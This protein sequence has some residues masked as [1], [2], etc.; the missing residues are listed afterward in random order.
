M[1]GHP[2]S[3]PAPRAG[4]V[5]LAGRSRRGVGAA[6]RVVS[7]WPPAHFPPLPAWVRPKSGPPQSATRPKA[8][9]VRGPWVE[10]GS[11]PRG[12]G[13]AAA[14]PVPTAAGTWA[15]L[16]C[17][18]FSLE[19]GVCWK[20]TREK[21]GDGPQG[22]GTRDSSCGETGARGEGGCLR[23]HS[24]AFAQMRRLRPGGAQPCSPGAWTAAQAS[25]SLH[26]PCPG[27]RAK[28]PGLR[29]RSSSSLV[30]TGGR[31]TWNS[32]PQSRRGPWPPRRCLAEGPLHGASAEG[33]SVGAGFSCPTSR[34][35]GRCRLP[36]RRW[37]LC[38]C[39]QVSTLCLGFLICKIRTRTGLPRR[40][41]GQRESR[42]QS[43]QGGC[44]EALGLW[45]RDP[46]WQ[47]PHPSPQPRLRPSNG[48]WPDGGHGPVT[49]PLRVPSSSSGFTSEA[50][51][52]ACVPSL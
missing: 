6:L 36:F 7:H 30:R 29:R 26:G 11:A 45:A 14:S 18:D 50:S 1:T 34:L 37:G 10:A 49:L 19:K 4:G 32:C 28:R 46:R 15:L 33:C 22:G 42:G 35:L 41:S 52:R 12:G 2:H 40:W 39:S 8:A 17:D 24:I 13:L 25:R 44:S 21:V 23:G 38:G 43:T 48:L 3:R 9:K 51:P 27:C 47:P 20:D 16:C 31:L 5:L